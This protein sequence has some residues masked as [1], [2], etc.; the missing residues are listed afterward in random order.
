M[1]GNDQ[2]VLS[3]DQDFLVRQLAWRAVA[4]IA[5]KDTSQRQRREALVRP[6]EIGDQP[7]AEAIEHLRLR[8]VCH[9]RIE[10]I[11]V[12]DPVFFLLGDPPAAPV[13]D[14]MAPPDRGTGLEINQPQFLGQ[15]PLQRYFRRLVSLDTAAGCDPETAAAMRRANPHQQD[16]AFTRDDERPDGAAVDHGSEQF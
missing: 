16:F 15:F 2:Q 12:N 11:R 10:S 4:Q 8:L 6:G 13:E 5:F 7:P 3:V 14:M 9:H 1:R